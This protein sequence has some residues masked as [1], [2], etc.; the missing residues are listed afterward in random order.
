MHTIDRF[1]FIFIVIR[2]N[3]NLDYLDNFTIKP[4]DIHGNGVFTTRPFQSGEIIGIG[5]EYYMYLFPRITTEFGSLINHS[6]SR[7]N[8][9]L[10]Y[11]NNKYYVKADKNIPIDTELLI[12]YDKCPWFIMGSQNWYIQ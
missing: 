3:S 6:S 5:I 10:I 2:M 4:S 1:E 12:N 7:P 8:V 11:L 9:S